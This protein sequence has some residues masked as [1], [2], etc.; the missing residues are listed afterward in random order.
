MEDDAGV[1]ADPLSLPVLGSM[2][3]V[4]M[5]HAL[6]TQ[7]PCSGPCVRCAVISFRLC[8]GRKVS[9][10]V[11]FIIRRPSYPP[12]TAAFSVMSNKDGVLVPICLSQRV[13]NSGG[14][15]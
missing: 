6:S 5:C 4:Q 7:R 12:L 3:P 15:E 1:R 14:E 9:F 13:Q 11:L 8:R 2:Y 10:N